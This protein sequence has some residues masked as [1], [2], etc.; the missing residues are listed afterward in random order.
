MGKERK[1]GQ[2]RNLIRRGIALG[3]S[4]VLVLGMCSGCG[5]RSTST[6][7]LSTGSRT[8]RSGSPPVERTAETQVPATEAPGMPV[9][10]EPTEKSPLVYEDTRAPHY[11]ASDP[12]LETLWFQWEC[13]D[14]VG[15]AR[16]GLQIDAQM[17]RYYRGLQRYYDVSSYGKYINDT[18]NRAVVQQVVKAMRDIADQLHYDDSAVAREMAQFVQNCIE[19]EYDS[20][21]AGQDEYP[22]YPIETL[23]ER[24]GDCE[25]TSILMAALLKEWGYEVGFFVLPGHIAVALR[26][27]DS[28]NDGPYYEL[29]GHRYLYIESTGSGWNI[30]EIPDDVRGSSVK[31]YLVS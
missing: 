9:S 8:R 6:K 21:S 20:D 18:N 30:G 4:L 10:P 15:T 7:Y 23:Y 24:R 25:D 12:Q 3:V 28:Y 27:S 22:R 2:L 13:Q 17:Y 14:G 29:N 26:T 31:L 5:R 19:Y 16:I 1:A 11:T